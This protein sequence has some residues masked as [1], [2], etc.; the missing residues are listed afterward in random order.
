MSPDRPGRSA[1]CSDLAGAT[2]NDDLDAPF[3][4]EGVCLHPEKE[5]EDPFTTRGVRDHKSE[6]RPAVTRAMS[7]PNHRRDSCAACGFVA[8]GRTTVVRLK[9]RGRSKPLRKP[10]R[11]SAVEGA[12]DRG[13]SP[14]HELWF[15]AP[16]KRLSADDLEVRC[17]RRRRWCRIAASKRRER[18]R[19][20]NRHSHK[21][22]R[23]LRR[24]HDRSLGRLRST[25]ARKP[26]HRLRERSGVSPDPD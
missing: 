3:V 26:G 5:P 14:G 17:D 20:R 24:Q 6:G 18:N 11:A 13:H 9:L 12:E 16:R 8:S 21:Y 15:T 22:R 1:P 19:Q 10:D 2:R 4:R 25:V 23:D 7:R